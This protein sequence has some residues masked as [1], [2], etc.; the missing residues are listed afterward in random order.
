MPQA[1]VPLLTAWENFYVIIGSSAAGL[2]GLMFV[3]ITLIAGAEGQR[4]DESVGAFGTPTV[5][6]FAVALL[7]AAVLSAPWQALWQPGIVLGLI[8][9]VGVIYII[10]V[11]HRAQRQTAYQ[12]VLEDWLWHMIFPFVSYAA[13]ITTAL[14]LPSQPVPALFIP[15]AA[16][17][18]LLF[19]GIHN[20]W[21]TVTFVTLQQSNQK[22]S[23]KS[24]AE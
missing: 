18:L 16:T 5:V 12:P 13:F 11:I 15:A 4:T 7:V 20:A 17:L 19:I 2:T 8:G 23:G 3:V 21:D 9:L 14:L 22:D 24:Q 10:I 6:H 1:G